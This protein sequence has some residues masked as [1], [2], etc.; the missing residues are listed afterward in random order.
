MKVELYVITSCSAIV[1]F[2]LYLELIF[3]LNYYVYLVTLKYHYICHV[4]LPSTIV[5][6]TDF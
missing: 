3:Y 4:L 6:S 2:R 1:A 5:T